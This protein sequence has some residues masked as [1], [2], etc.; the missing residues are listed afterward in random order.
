MEE[1]IK[2]IVFDPRLLISPP[3]T[4][5]PK[6]GSNLFGILAI[7]NYHYEKR[8]RECMYPKGN[9]TSWTIALPKLKKKVIYLDQ[10]AISNMMKGLNPMYKASKSKQL[11][12]IWLKLFEKLDKL[13]KMQIIICPSSSF[14]EEESSLSSYYSSLRKMY[15]LL[16]GGTKFINRLQLQIYQTLDALECFINNEEYSFLKKKNLSEVLTDDIDGWQDRIFITVH[17]DCT[18]NEVEKARELRNEVSEEFNRKLFQKWQLEKSKEF[19]DFLKIEENATKDVILNNYVLHWIVG[20]QLGK[21]YLD[22]EELKTKFLD[23][24]S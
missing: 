6:C 1:K 18:E 21:K 8:C 16:G 10:M 23:F 9:E 12:A 19:N 13:S 11:D 22:K 4:K 2:E 3:F 14:Q 15:E 5:C 17:M 7:R 20:E 24:I